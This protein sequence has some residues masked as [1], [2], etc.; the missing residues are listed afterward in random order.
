M[1]TWIERRTEMLAI[2]NPAAGGG[3]ALKKWSRIVPR[4]SEAV[5]PLDIFVST[6]RDHL[7]EAMPGLLEQGHREFIAAG[8]DGTVNTVLGAITAH[9]D[10]ELLQGITVGAVGL[11]SSNDFHKPFQR[12]IGNVPCRID[13][14][15]SRC[16]DIGVLSYD[17]AQGHPRV[18]YWFINASIGIAAEANRFFNRPDRLLRALKRASTSVAI[19]YAALA[20]IVTNRPRDLALAIDGRPCANTGVRN[21]GVVKNPHFAGS[22]RYESPHQQDSGFFHVHR[23]GALSRF[24]LLR[25]LARLA[26]GRFAGGPETRSWRSRRATVR[27]GGDPFLVECDGEVVEALSA[28]FLISSRKLRLC[29]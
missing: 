24:G 16:H 23:L 19:A 13:F 6:S 20:A 15:D 9:A 18:R 12:M 2:I 10:P 1:G 5:G 25:A 11:G 17:D 22:L 14:D 21:L 26:R 27:H 3:K 7:E 28:S 29:S 4:L 8:G